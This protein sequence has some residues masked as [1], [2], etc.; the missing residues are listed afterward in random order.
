MAVEPGTKL[1]GATKDITSYGEKSTNMHNLWFCAHTL[2]MN[3]VTNTFL[4][5]SSSVR[6]KKLLCSESDKG[7]K[8]EQNILTKSF[9]GPHNQYPLLNL[10]NSIYRS[11]QLKSLLYCY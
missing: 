7:Q 2:F 9:V 3:N 1:K 5:P 10:H 4:L 8:S 6:N 11:E